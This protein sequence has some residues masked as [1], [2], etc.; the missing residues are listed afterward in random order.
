MISLPSPAREA[1][2]DMAFRGQCRCQMARPLALRMKTGFYRVHRPVLDTPGVR[3]FGAS[4]GGGIDLF[5][6]ALDGAFGGALDAFD[7][8]GAEEPCEG[9]AVSGVGGEAAQTQSRE[10]T[11]HG[12]AQADGG[13]KAETI[14]G[15]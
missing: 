14:D 4:Q 8:C 6:E 10:G 13:L 1:A 5:A 2:E 11:G 9:G 7:V 12:A 15:G 3:S